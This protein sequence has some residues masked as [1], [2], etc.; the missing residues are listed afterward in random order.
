M[1]GA[2]GEQVAAASASGDAGGVVVGVWVSPGAGRLEDPGVRRG[3]ARLG[4]PEAPRAAVPGG[5]EGEARAL[6]RHHSL[7]V[8]RTHLQT[9]RAHRV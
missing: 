6:A 3:L 9:H 4:V 2:E 1:V 7:L 8:V 5:V